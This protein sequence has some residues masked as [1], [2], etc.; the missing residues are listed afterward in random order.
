[1]RGQAVIRPK[2]NPF[3][4][5]AMLLEHFGHGLVRSK[6]SNLSALSIVA[7]GEKRTQLPPP[8]PPKRFRLRRE[9]LP[10]AGP[11]PEF[12]LAP[13]WEK[14]VFG[15]V[16]SVFEPVAPP[17]RPLW[18]EANEATR[19]KTIHRAAMPNCFRMANHSR[20]KGR[21]K[22]V[23]ARGSRYLEEIVR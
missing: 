19:G 23:F 17:F 8:D 7:G 13:P 18:H 9:E 11:V 12:A 5:S 16:I 3:K 2:P 21:C 15:S 1:M 14:A 22:P 10:P 20:V 6:K 4:S